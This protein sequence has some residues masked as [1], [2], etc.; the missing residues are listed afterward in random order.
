[1]GE[2]G[3]VRGGAGQV[4]TGQV[5]TGQVSTSW[6]GTVQ[7]RTGEVKTSQAGQVSTGQN[8]HV[9]LGTRVWPYSVLL[10]ILCVL[11]ILDPE[12]KFQHNLGHLV[13]IIPW[14]IFLTWK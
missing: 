13:N 11:T 8:G 6:F 12:L 9:L 10:V 5:G 2:P 1:M 14:S 3:A 4:V 7:V